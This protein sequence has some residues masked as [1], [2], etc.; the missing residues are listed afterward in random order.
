[1]YLHATLTSESFFL[2]KCGALSKAGHDCA[3]E[4]NYRYIKV[5]DETEKKDVTVQVTGM[6]YVERFDCIKVSLRVHILTNLLPPDSKTDD[7]FS[8]DCDNSAKVL[9]TIK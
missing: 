5:G 6:S 2:F 4:P 9:Y 8:L 1:M 3:Y 7:I